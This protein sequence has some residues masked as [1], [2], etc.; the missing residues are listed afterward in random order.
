VELSEAIQDYKRQEA[1][2]DPAQAVRHVAGRVF[3]QIEGVWLDSRYREPMKRIVVSFAGEE[4]FKL[5]K[6]RPDL[7]P[8]LALGVKVI[9]CLDDQTA[10]VV[11]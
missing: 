3:Y 10:V 5:L 2:T 11:E 6:D 8:C 4:Y 1:V 9:V 7:K